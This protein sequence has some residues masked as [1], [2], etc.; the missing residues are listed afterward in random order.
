MIRDAKTTIVITESAGDAALLQ[1][2]LSPIEGGKLYF[3]VAGGIN[4]AMTAASTI[5]NA[6]RENVLMVIDNDGARD[7]TETEFIRE[8][9]GKDSQRFKLV[10][11]VPEIESLFFAD[12]VALEQA[13]GTRIE[14]MIWEI[15][16]TAPKSTLDV[17]LKKLG[18]K[19]RLE[20]LSSQAL[21]SAMRNHPKIKEIQEFAQVAHA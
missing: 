10:L 18:K 3:D 11:M 4:H 14:D 7:N 21:L 15:A 5:L 1:R 2:V 13:L 20:L 6:R 8:L 12:R 9:V 16:M 19:D 17:L